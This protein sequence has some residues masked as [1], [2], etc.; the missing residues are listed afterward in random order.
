MR[1]PRGAQSL[2]VQVA[3]VSCLSG[4]PMLFSE[5]PQQCCTSPHRVFSCQLTLVLSGVWSPKPEPQHP[6]PTHCCKL[7]GNSVSA[8]KC[9]FAV[10]PPFHLL[11]T[12]CCIPLR[13]SEA[14]P[15]HTWEGVSECEETFPP[16]WLPPQGTSPCPEILC[17]FTF[18][19]FLSYLIRRRLTYLLAV[20]VLPPAF[21]RCSVGTVS[22]ADGLWGGGWFPPLFPL[23]SWKSSFSSCFRKFDD[24]VLSVL[25]CAYFT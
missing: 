10:I 9:W 6:A 14:P 2:R 17:P 24:N 25:L 5:L 19:Y 7:Q 18:L 12:C 20:W 16:S 4:G 11:S 15:V 1:G 23:P 8:G 3:M 22:H 21:R 13:G